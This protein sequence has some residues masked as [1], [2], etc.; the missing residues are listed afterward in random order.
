[1]VVAACPAWQAEPI[2]PIS[3]ANCINDAAFGDRFVSFPAVGRRAAVRAVTRSLAPKQPKASR[4]PGVHDAGTRAAMRARKLARVA[5]P[6][7]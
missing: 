2:A 5:V 1:M 3:A 4:M 7:A 6:A